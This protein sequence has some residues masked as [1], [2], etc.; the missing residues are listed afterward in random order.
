VIKDGKVSWQP[1]LDLNQ[2]ILTSN[3]VACMALLTLRRLLRR[4]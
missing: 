1:A 4:H 2:V 3:L